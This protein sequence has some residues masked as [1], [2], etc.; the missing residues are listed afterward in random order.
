[1]SEKIANVEALLLNVPAA[2]YHADKTFNIPSLS[3]SLAKWLITDTPRHAWYSCEALNPK[4]RRKHKG[5]YDRGSAAHALLLKSHDEIV[6]VGA[7]DWRTQAARAVRDAAH[8]SGKIPMLEEDFAEL[9][10]MRDAQHDQLDALEGGNP[11]WTGEPEVCMY[12]LDDFFLNGKHYKVRCRARLDWLNTEMENLV[13]VK[14]TELTANPE[15]W[16]RGYMWRIGAPYQAAFTRR[17][18]R[19][20]TQLGVLKMHDP[21]FL[22]CVCESQPPYGVSLISVPSDI[23]CPYSDETADDRVVKAMATW[24]DCLDANEWPGYPPSVYVAKSRER[25]ARPKWD[26][27]QEAPPPGSHKLSDDM[28]DEAFSRIEFKRK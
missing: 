16:T 6:R 17:G 10:E 27:P 25:T 8:A 21:D 3:G 14:T 22:F 2:T 9:I 15:V 26:M 18:I 24:Q 19:R 23:L 13:D 1:M 4:F 7:I 5:I 12:W 20:L 11:F 28:P